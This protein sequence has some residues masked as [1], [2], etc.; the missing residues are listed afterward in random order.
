M[1]I[2]HTRLRIPK[3]LPLLQR[4]HD[5]HQYRRFDVVRGVIVDDQSV[6]DPASTVVA[7]VDYLSVFAEDGLQR[8]E[9]QST[10]GAF[11]GFG[12]QAGDAVAGE[13]GDEEGDLVLEGGDDVT[14]PFW[15]IGLLGIWMG[16]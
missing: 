5:I 10:Y 7:A 6:S 14:P 1:I 2:R 11:V 15:G 4:R 8:F 13:F 9:Y 16:G 12:G 3:R